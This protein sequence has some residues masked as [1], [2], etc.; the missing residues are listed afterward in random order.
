MTFR[1]YVHVHIHTCIHKHVIAHVRQ[2]KHSDSMHTG[3]Q[4]S[5]LYMSED[6]KLIKVNRAQLDERG[7]RQ[8][9]SLSPQNLFIARETTFDVCLSIGDSTQGYYQP[10]EGRHPTSLG[11]PELILKPLIAFVN[12]GP[13]SARTLKLP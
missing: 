3:L 10:G 9:R 1:K 8:P 13:M 2:G 5:L 11:L 4:C 12:E 7:C 6:K